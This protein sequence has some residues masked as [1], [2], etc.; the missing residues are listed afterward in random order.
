MVNDGILDRRTNTDL[1]IGISVFKEQ[2]VCLAQN[3]HRDIPGGTPVG[4]LKEYRFLL[5]GK[6][7]SFKMFDKEMYVQGWVLEDEDEGR[8]FGGLP[9]KNK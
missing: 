3:S 1:G 2:I 5:V 6:K 4:L 8:I 7:K 9:Q